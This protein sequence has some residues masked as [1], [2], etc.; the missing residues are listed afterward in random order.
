MHIQPS[1]VQKIGKISVGPGGRLIPTKNTL[2]TFKYYPE[3]TE[4]TIFASAAP[5]RSSP[6]TTTTTTI[7]STTTIEQTTQPEDIFQ[8]VSRNESDM[9]RKPLEEKSLN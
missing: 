1:Y 9:I 7:E 8:D 5:R 2:V 6:T 3:G 4:R